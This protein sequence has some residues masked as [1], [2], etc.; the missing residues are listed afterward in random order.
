MIELSKL[1]ERFENNAGWIQNLADFPVGGVQLIH[2]VAGSSRSHHAHKKDGHWLYC[3]S[4]RFEYLERPLGSSEE[5]SRRT[6]CPGD[7]VFTGPGIEHSTYFLEDT[8]LISMSLQ[9][10]THEAHESDL[11]RVAPLPLT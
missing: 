6:I 9:P 4:G 3:V 10:R 5:P 11:I 1:G 2:S 7:M 8:V